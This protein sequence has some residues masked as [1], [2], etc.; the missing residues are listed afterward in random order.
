MRARL[1]AARVRLMGFD[2]DGVL[3]DA[4]LYFG[5]EGDALKA[6]CARD[7]H[8]IKLLQAAGVEVAI[9]TGRSSRT[10]EQRASN[11]GVRHLRQGVEDKRAAL[12]EIA[13]ALGTDL[14]H[15]GYM[16]DDVLDL[17]VLRACG[18]SATVAD[19]HELV[20]RHV[21]YVARQPGGAGAVREVCE[22]LLASQGL[23]EAA[24]APYLK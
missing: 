14:A 19:G 4:R 22:L 15:C 18:F 6:F 2:V 7:G 12:A 5:P 11:L 21:D 3:T 16:G 9:V 17:P 1:A 24:L 10:V 23:L 20:R 13:H 8:G